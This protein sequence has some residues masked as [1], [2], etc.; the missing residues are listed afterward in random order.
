M[1]QGDIVEDLDPRLAEEAGDGWLIKIRVHGA[2]EL[3]FACD[4]GLDHGDIGGIADGNC[5]RRVRRDEFAR[6]P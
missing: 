2:N 1:H 5:Q 3:G 4:G 6:L